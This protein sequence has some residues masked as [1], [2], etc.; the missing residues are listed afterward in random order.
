[1]SR[2]GIIT[3]SFEPFHI[4]HMSIGFHA[5]TQLDM[6]RV[7][8]VPVAQGPGRRPS[9]T[10]PPLKKVYLMN[11]ALRGSFKGVDSFLQQETL[12]NAVDVV[13]KYY[14]SNELFLLMGRS[15]DPQELGLTLPKDMTILPF[16][17]PIVPCSSTMLRNLLASPNEDDHVRALAWIP[18][19]MRAYIQ[20]NNPYKE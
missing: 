14:P 20:E 2:I 13:H 19:T 12:Q 1:M 5:L 6:D 4:G 15:L 9:R 8:Y 18:R 17:R 10:M 16:P 7:V 11:Q 3:G